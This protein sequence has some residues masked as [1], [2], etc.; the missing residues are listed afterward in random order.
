MTIESARQRV[1]AHAIDHFRSV[2]PAGTPVSPLL[3]NV[4]FTQPLK[5]PEQELLARL[6]ADGLEPVDGPIPEAA[7]YLAAARIEA[8]WHEQRNV[9][10]YRSVASIKDRPALQWWIPLIV[11]CL[12]GV[13]GAGVAANDPVQRV[14]IEYVSGRREP[15]ASAK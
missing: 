13:F 3:T 8:Q 9:V 7:W 4:D 5:D 12:A 2:Y 14:I 10:A 11:R 15:F 6:Y 1:N